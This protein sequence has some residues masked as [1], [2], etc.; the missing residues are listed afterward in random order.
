MVGRRIVVSYLEEVGDFLVD[1]VYPP[2]PVLEGLDRL[3]RLEG[4]LETAKQ[5]A[6]WSAGPKEQ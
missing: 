6:P 3:A 1:P 4:G 2:H 5:G